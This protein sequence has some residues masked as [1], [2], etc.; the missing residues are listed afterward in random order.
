MLKAKIYWA[1]LDGNSLF[2]LILTPF[3]EVNKIIKDYKG[4]NRGK[5]S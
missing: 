2:Q 4:T 3:S 5:K 1:K